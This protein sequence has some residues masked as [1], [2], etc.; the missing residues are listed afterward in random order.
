MDV[1][2]AL[3]IVV[4]TYGRD[5]VLIET[6][7]RLFAL[8]PHASETIVVDQSE[9][10]CK[11]VSRDLDAWS[12]SGRI[13]WLRLGNPNIPRAMN[14]GL[15][16]ASHNFV[17]FLDDDIVPRAGIVEGHVAALE[18]TGAALVAG[19]VIQ[20]WQIGQDFSD[21]KEFHFASLRPAW[22]SNFMGGNF[23]V[24]R[25]IARRLGGFDERFVRV[26]Y[27]F[28]SEFAYRLSQAGYRIFYEPAAC[29]HH[30]RVDGGGTRT[31]GDHLRSYQPNHAVGAYYFILRTW[32]GWKSLA[33]F[34]G[35]P[36]RAVAT[37]HHLRRPW[38]IPITFFA[39]LSGMTWAL[40]LA[41]KGP[42]YLDSEELAKGCG[43]Q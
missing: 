15:L 31:F 4:P 2:P 21:E 7:S 40:A 12:A 30:L 10:H 18:K 36:L 5:E 38:W 3:T 28:E 41:A 11:H 39:E 24:H 26:A 34:L 25:G 42:R 13:R 17:L 37:R 20:P 32:S 43:F 33:R 19:R 9:K 6:L 29:V 27:N 22:V 1:S 35:R 16:E 8:N 23:S 14:V